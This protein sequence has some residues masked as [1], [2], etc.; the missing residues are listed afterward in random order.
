MSDLLMLTGVY[1]TLDGKTKY[2]DFKDWSVFK[3]SFDK[4]KVVS[5]RQIADNNYIHYEEFQQLIDMIDDGISY[6]CTLWIRRTL[7]DSL[8][9]LDE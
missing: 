1:L 6:E 7:E 2:V 8:A 4:V 3:F 5:L 9:S